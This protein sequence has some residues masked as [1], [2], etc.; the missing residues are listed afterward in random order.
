MATR[1]R[2]RA[3]PKTPAS[4]PASRP[5]RGWW[6]AVVMVVLTGLVILR[7][8]EKAPAPKPRPEAPALKPEHAR[9]LEQ[10]RTLASAHA[11]AAPAHQDH[12]AAETEAIDDDERNR[13]ENQNDPVASLIPLL[14]GETPEQQLTYLKWARRLPE[15]GFVAVFPDL[16]AAGDLN[17]DERARLGSDAL[18]GLIELLERQ[19]VR[20]PELPADVKPVQVVD[21]PPPVEM[22]RS[23]RDDYKPFPGDP[24]R[25][26]PAASALPAPP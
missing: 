1:E 5:G 14:A 11:P 3:A 18:D 25:H 7:F 15:A 8:A 24:H 2:Q 22:P 26:D 9:A 12:P 17:P 21:N 16:V 19:G 13:L 4:P 20:V 23:L 6:L 10:L